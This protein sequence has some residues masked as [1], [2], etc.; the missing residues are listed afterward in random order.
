MPFDRD[1]K[2]DRYLSFSRSPFF[3]N[4]NPSA[5]RGES[6]LGGALFISMDPRCPSSQP[7]RILFVQLVLLLIVGAATAQQPTQNQQ[8]PG[9]PTG[10][11]RGQAPE[12][13]A[14]VPN[15]PM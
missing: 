2:S 11:T 12:M 15:R 13:P 5:V 4:K 3:N 10:Q 1:L 6:F 9:L 8:T 14:T 7:V